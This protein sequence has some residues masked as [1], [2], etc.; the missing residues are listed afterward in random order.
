[1]STVNRWRIL[2]YVVMA[3]AGILA[4][5]GFAS[6]SS[7]SS[8]TSRVRQ[9]RDLLI[10]DDDDSQ[11]GNG[12]GADGSQEAVD[13][14]ALI[15]QEQAAKEGLDEVQ[16]WENAIWDKEENGQN[17]TQEDKD[18][19]DSL[20]GEANV[21]MNIEVGTK[22]E[23]EDLKAQGGGNV[24]SAT[25]DPPIVTQQEEVENEEDVFDE[26][27]EAP[28]ASQRT[29][30]PTASQRTQAPTELVYTPADDDPIVDKETN[31]DPVDDDPILDE[32][33]EIVEQVEKEL[34]KQEKVARTAGGFGFVIAI[35]AMIF[36]AHQMS[37]NPD[38]IFA[39]YV[40]VPSVVDFSRTGVCVL[41]GGAL[42]PHSHKSFVATASVDSQSPWQVSSSR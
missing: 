42:F 21:L 9:R 2:L 11:L 40:P 6:S 13:V 30:A 39:R 25:T 29:Q 27:A 19:L 17:L 15:A 10:A 34:A 41:G 8:S 36:T 1:M 14:D 23:L 37:E 24:G 38:G 18:V 5:H 31:Y 26:L 28:T 7:S 32:D 12:A 4:L 16:H 22:Q 33:E 20:E 3:L 35:C